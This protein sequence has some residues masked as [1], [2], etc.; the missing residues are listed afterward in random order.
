MHRSL[1]YW[2]LSSSMADTKERRETQKICLSDPL[3][4]CAG[5]YVKR[6]RRAK[7]S[8][9][10]TGSTYAPPLKGSPAI[11]RS[12]SPCA[13]RSRTETSQH[14]ANASGIETIVGGSIEKSPVG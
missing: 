11:A 6:D 7:G 13:L 1:T 9:R 10:L 5:L 12:R 14:A 2:Q 3:R 4:S 8:Q